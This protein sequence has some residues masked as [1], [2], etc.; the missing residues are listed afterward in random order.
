M[1]QLCNQEQRTLELEMKNPPNKSPV[2]HELLVQAS[3]ND[4][5]Y[6]KTTRVLNTWILSF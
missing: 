1:A 5:V 2:Y 4:Q 6:S 3:K